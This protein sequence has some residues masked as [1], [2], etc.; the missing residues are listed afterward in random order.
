MGRSISNPDPRGKQVLATEGFFFFFLQ[1][2][3]LRIWNKP[4]KLWPPTVTKASPVTEASTGRA[5]STRSPWCELFF[6]LKKINIFNYPDSPVVDGN[7]FCDSVYKT[8]DSLW[9]K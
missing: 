9:E 5:G 2:N 7:G 6:K 3:L 1:Q 4:G 8:S